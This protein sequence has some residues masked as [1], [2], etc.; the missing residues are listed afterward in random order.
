MNVLDE[1]FCVGQWKFHLVLDRDYNLFKVGRENQGTLCVL[2]DFRQIF[3]IGDKSLT[4]DV[5]KKYSNKQV[6]ENPSLGEIYQ[7][8]IDAKLKLESSV[9]D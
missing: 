5:E 7:K 1:L 4:C 3:P 2:G 6:I 9:N 8:K